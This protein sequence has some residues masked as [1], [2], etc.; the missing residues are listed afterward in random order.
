MSESTF[1]QKPEDK[2]RNRL[3]LHNQ[4]DELHLKRIY[5]AFHTIP[6]RKME[7]DELAKLLY[8]VANVWY[9]ERDFELIFCRINT[10]RDGFVTWDE[11]ISYLILG[12]KEMEIKYEYQSLDLPI[13]KMPRIVRSKH[14]HPVNRIT[15]FQM[16]KKD[17]TYN[18]TDGNYLSVS[19]DGGINY[20]SL[21]LKLD[22]SVQSSSPELKIQQTWILDI[23]CLPD[24]TI[25]CT[26]STERDLRF[27]D[28]SAR[29]FELRIMFSS[30][31]DAVVS[32]HYVF[33]VDDPTKC[34]LIMGDMR[35]SVRILFFNSIERGP[36][37]SQPGTP[38]LHVRFDRV[39]K[40]LVPG[41][42]VVEFKYL[43]GDWVRQVSYYRSLHCFISCSSCV[44]ASMYI[45]DVN[46][47]KISYLYKVPK[48][49]WCF[50]VVEAVHILA[51]GGSDSLVRIWNSFVPNKPIAVL[52]GHHAGVCYVVFQDVGKKLFS[53][54]KDKCIKVWDVLAQT[55]LQTYL[56]VPQELGEHNEFTV[57]YNPDNRDLLMGSMTIVV[58]KLCPL[59]SGEHTDGTT[60]SLGVSVVLYNTL[61]KVVL[62]CGLDSVIIVWDPWTG[63]R[64]LVV[65][66]AHTRLVH[67]E[68]IP[69]EITAATFDPGNQLL[70]TGASNGSLKVWNFNTGTCLRNMS[71]E[72][73]CEVTAVIWIRGRILAI[74]WNK[75][76]IEFADSDGTSSTGGVFSKAWDTKHN[77]D[78]L[79]A[80]VRIPQTLVT[81]TYSGEL[82][83]WRLE[84]GQPYK[85]FN[86]ADPT[87]Q[88]KLEYTIHKDD[89][90]KRAITGQQRM[91]R[92]ARTVAI[93][94][95]IHKTTKKAAEFPLKPIVIALGNPEARV[96]KISAAT[97]PE[98]CMPLRGLAVYSMIFLSSR[99]MMPGVATLLVAVENGTVQV[100]SHHPGGSFITAFQV[101]HTARDY[102]TSMA[103][104]ESNE[105]LFT[106]TNTGYIKVWLMIDYYQPEQVKVC[107]PKYRLMFPFLLKTVILGR[108]KR[109]NKSQ[110]KPT[111][112]SSY[113]AHLLPV[114]GLTYINEAQILISASADCTAR[115]W[116]LGG[117]YLG[118]LGT[119]KPW[120]PIHI[121]SPLEEDHQ[122]QIP[123]DIK[124]IASFTTMQ[125]FTGGQRE[126]KVTKIDDD[127]ERSTV[128]IDMAKAN[129]YGRRLEEPILGNYFK[130]PPRITGKYDFA[131][132][133]SFPYI[134]IYQHLVMSPIKP[135][136]RPRTPEGIVVL[137]TKYD[138]KLKLQNK[139]S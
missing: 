72:S 59:Q 130:I 40:G 78:V 35:G 119:F 25:V 32:M 4:L 21:D 85:R 107:M 76:V 115:L 29:K 22:R 57:F 114:S 126:R 75:H 30:L 67:G 109:A 125:V 104:D 99:V 83:L 132:D 5:Y 92:A 49:I 105:F 9:D 23:V 88:I 117:R 124:R 26:S 66:E 7:K 77:E 100:W 71:I 101:T 68:A 80:A 61:F 137:R 136:S 38:L 91:N 84:T 41:F 47:N 48:G 98:T 74:G 18:H 128:H 111:L 39:I 27:Y 121:D 15:F 86:V 16:K 103:T 69:V 108:A 37:K 139:P 112:L 135:I 34:K 60:H 17:G 110:L 51:T 73:E 120:I 102:V 131:L 44:K 118:T 13:T 116:T 127:K 54:S 134:P 113:K 12:F 65:R 123:T 94:S 45:K 42:N 28:T 20:W 138:E 96:T 93:L 89:D 62:T 2:H 79:C 36:F 6:T 50:D 24:V 19:K 8:N 11:F 56:N 46:I 106:G 97:V 90:K 58:L 133:T 3:Y 70:L 14:R 64:M 53:I 82:V 10:K 43:H 129:I 63:R 1:R 55:C 122:Y 31:E 52:A 87:G 81:S 95:R 33:H